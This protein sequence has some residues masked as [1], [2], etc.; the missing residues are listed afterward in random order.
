MTAHR[1][2]TLIEL[3]IVVAIIAILAAIAF[4]AY[5]DYTIRSQVSEGITLADGAKSS[6]WD[7]MSNTGR[8][9]T[10]NASTGLPMDT[11]IQGNYVSQVDINT[12]V[13]VAT[14]GN[15]SNKR[16]AGGTLQMSP[17]TKPGSLQWRCKSSLDGKYLPTPCRS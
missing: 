12:G 15:K 6:V 11:S 7:F 2:F 4:P 8:L 1:G 14:F 10:N 3:M 17:T 16:L 5:Q 9:P 13:I